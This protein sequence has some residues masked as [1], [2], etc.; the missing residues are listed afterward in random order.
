VDHA[1]PSQARL[2]TYNST[3]NPPC[4]EIM[5]MEAYK[6]GPGQTVWYVVDAWKANELIRSTSPIRMDLPSWFRGPLRVDMAKTG[7]D[8]WTIAW[9]T[10]PEASSYGVLVRIDGTL[11]SVL[12]NTS[13]PP[14]Q[15]QLNLSGLTSGTQYSVYVSGEVM[16]N[17]KR[18]TRAGSTMYTAP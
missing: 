17:G 14:G 1:A 6:V 2:T 9:E 13:I 18:Q 12:N 3:A 4:C 15:T 16:W 5:D 8:Q 7:N 10:F 11:I